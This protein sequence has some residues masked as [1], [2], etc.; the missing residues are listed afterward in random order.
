MPRGLSIVGR[1]RS[2]RPPP[3]PI[4]SISF[5]SKGTFVIQEFVFYATTACARSPPGT[6]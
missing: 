6:G 2:P 3:G 5:R 4:A 1:K